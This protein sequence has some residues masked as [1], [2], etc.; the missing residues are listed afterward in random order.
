MTALLTTT[1]VARV[2]AVSDRTVRRLVASGEL[3]P[4]TVGPS[5]RLVRFTREE[6]DRYL[7][8]HSRPEPGRWR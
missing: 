4:I 8:P 5:R 2:L 7:S 1:D 6:I 3:R